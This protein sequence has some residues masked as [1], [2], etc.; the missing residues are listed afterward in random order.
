LKNNSSDN[1]LDQFLQHYFEKF[2]LKINE[3]KKEFS[4]QNNFAFLNY[5]K[6]RK[7][8]I[9]QMELY[10]IIEHEIAKFLEIL[11]DVLDQNSVAG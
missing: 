2:L 6:K 5:E 7:K 11:N 9:Y 4:T 1:S 10:P 8:I 3:H